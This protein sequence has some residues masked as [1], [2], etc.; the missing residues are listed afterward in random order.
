[1]DHF[2]YKNTQLFCEEVFLGDI[3]E[4]YGTPI[5]KLEQFFKK[6]KKKN[7]ISLWNS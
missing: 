4:K 2:N 7:I 1:M 3:A 6:N 5:Y